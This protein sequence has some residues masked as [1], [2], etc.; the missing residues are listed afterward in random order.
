MGLE[1]D[2]PSSLEEAVETLSMRG[3]NARPLAGGTALVLLLGQGLVSLD[4]LVDLRHIPGLDAI[5]HEPGVGLRIGTLVTHRALERSPLV[6]ARLP[7]LAQVF[8]HVANVRVRNQATVGGVL[9]EADYASDP[10]AALIALNA[11]V[12]VAGPDGERELPIAKLLRGWY[13]TS[14]TGGEVIREVIVPDPESET[15]FAYRRFV[16]RST[17]DRPCASVAIAARSSADRCAEL[18]VVVGAVAATPQRFP[19]VEELAHGEPISEALA[20]RI[21]GAY[22][23]RIEPL[24][25]ARGSAEYRR[26]VVEVLLRRTLLEVAR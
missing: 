21:A 14:L 24:S 17:Q 20:R 7:Y 16:S 1:I 9:A 3:E 19:E 23:A 26:E 11:R 13:E 5:E 2:R 18:R 6:Q 4:H 10:P 12:R 8:H 22:A 25:D 15:T